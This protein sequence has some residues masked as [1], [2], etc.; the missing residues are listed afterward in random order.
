MTT[1]VSHLSPALLSVLKDFETRRLW[2][3][4]QLDYQNGKLVVIRKQETI[5]TEEDNR[6][7][8]QRNYYNNR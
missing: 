7:G 6:D 1:E 5:K 3:Q 4:I 2:G 8:K